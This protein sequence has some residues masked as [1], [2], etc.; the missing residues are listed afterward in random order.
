[1]TT[2]NF[3]GFFEISAPYVA[4]ILFYLVTAFPL[5]RYCLD[6]KLIG[7]VKFLRAHGRFSAPSVRVPDPTLL[8]FRFKPA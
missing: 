1:M 2:A 7:L 8:C 5:L 3:E 6:F 4:Y